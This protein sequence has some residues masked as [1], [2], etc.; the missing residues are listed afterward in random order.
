MITQSGFADVAKTV[1]QARGITVIELIPDFLVE[2]GIFSLIGGE[3]QQSGTDGFAQ[4]DDVALV[5]HTSG[6]TSRPKIVPLTHKNL[7]A[8]TQNISLSLNLSQSDRCLN[9]MPHS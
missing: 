4:A 7:W 2:A 8:S 5:L 6:T 1:A 3:Y 9:I